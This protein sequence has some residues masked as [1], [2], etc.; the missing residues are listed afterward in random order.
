ME[1]TYQQA[2]DLRW[3]VRG[4]CATRIKTR[5]T[6]ITCNMHQM[7]HASHATRITCH[8]H[9]MQLMS[10]TAP[11]LWYN[12]LRDSHHSGYGMGQ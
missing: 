8:T 7:P 12:S 2:I 6:R 5:T 9:H 3:G 4:V 1:L 10:G 11:S